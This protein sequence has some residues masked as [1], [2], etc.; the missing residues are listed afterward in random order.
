MAP[1][2]VMHGQISTK[3]DVYSFGV[4]LLEIVTGKRCAGYY[5]SNPPTDLISYIWRHWEEGNP[6]QVLDEGIA[7]GCSAE[8]VL[9]HIHIGLL[10][11]QHDPLERPSMS[12]VV[13]MLSSYSTSLPAVSPLSSFTY[14]ST[15]T[16]GDPKVTS[17]PMGGPSIPLNPVNDMSPIN[18]DITTLEPR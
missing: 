14:M 13:L 9:R 3:S 1:E 2:Y 6:V 7:D 16:N 8:E 12:L 5:G 15:V 10:C 4:L 18:S 11:I 17:T